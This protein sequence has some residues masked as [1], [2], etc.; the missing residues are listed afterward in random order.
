LAE[1]VESSSSARSSA[2]PDPTQRAGGASASGKVV[3]VGFMCAG[4]SRST[5]KL[6]PRAGHEALDADVL[7]EERLGEP[8]ASF[9]A[10]E[11]EAAFRRH[12]RELVLELLE[13]PGHA[14]V[15]LGGGAIES[16]EVR[17]ALAAHTVVYVEVDA[18]TA[19]ARAE[20]SDRPLAQDRARFFELFAR[21]APLYEQVADVRLAWSDVGVGHPSFVGAGALELAGR[22]WPRADGRAF[23][24][25]D[26]RVDELHGETLRQALSES[27]EVAGTIGIPPGE[28]SKSLAEAERILRELAA[29]GMQRADTIV[30]LG[31]GVAGDLAGFCAATYQRGVAVVHVPTTVVAQ[32]DSAYGGK[33]GVDIP[34]G[35]NY[36]GAFHQPAAVITDPSTLTTL[37][38]AELCAGFAEVLK[39]GLIAGGCLWDDVRTMPPLRDA[40]DTDIE[41]ATRVVLGCVR[42]KQRVVAEDELDD[43]VRAS[44]NLGHTFA[45]A[46]ESATGYTRFRHG[47]AVALGLRVALRLSERFAGL[48][49]AVGGEVQELLARHGLPLGFEGPPTDVLIEH[50]G[51][52]K[53]R[54]GD[55]RNLVLLRAPGEVEIEAE[56]PLA[57]LQRAID[58]IRGGEG[59]A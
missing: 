21:R 45:H 24:V 53:K 6:A 2:R 35:K 59:A 11:G 17:D 40:L 13:R 12:E 9:F 29:A 56:V 1:I 44:L 42:L 8:I 27:V 49:P 58:E 39:T 22:L 14:Y 4:K 16:E 15:P 33:T 34:E 30:A 41:L 26:E 46:L 47:E 32:M 3:L 25:A 20:G 19:W 48:D 54:R 50:A 28:P 36:V 38:D 10:R 31:G 5:R 57:A 52:D 37:P 43:G 55:R 51:R 23:V 7:L 18:D